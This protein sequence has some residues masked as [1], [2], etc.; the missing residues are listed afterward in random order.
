[1]GN[2][3][4]AYG[5]PLSSYVF[6]STR[7]GAATGLWVVNVL[8]SRSGS[9]FPAVSQTHYTHHSKKVV[10][11]GGAKSAQAGGRVHGRRFKRAKSWLCAKKAA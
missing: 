1:M 11:S 2:G 10:Q 6:P 3:S 8:C 4:I 5:M 7:G 9:S